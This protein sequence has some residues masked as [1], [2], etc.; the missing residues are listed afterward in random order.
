MLT[1]PFQRIFQEVQGA[2]SGVFCTEEYSKLKPLVYWVS[3]YPGAGF[4]DS[5]PCGED[6]APA[7]V[8]LMP[9]EI[10]SYTSAR[11][12]APPGTKSASLNIALPC[13]S[14]ITSVSIIADQ[15][16]YSQEDRPILEINVMETLTK[17]KM[18]LVW[19]TFD[20]PGDS[21]GTPRNTRSWIE[22]GTMVSYPL[23][24]STHGSIIFIK[25]SLPENAGPLA[26]IH[27]G[28][29]L[30]SGKPLLT[31]KSLGNFVHYPITNSPQIPDEPLASSPEKSVTDKRQALQTTPPTL[32]SL[33]KKSFVNNIYFNLF[34]LIFFYS[35]Q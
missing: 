30:I 6:S 28:K 3:E 18:S 16:G 10:V 26:R 24:E 27:M 12:M 29:I 25:V 31:G 1:N 14:L 19:D 7:E 32:F 4:I 21:C 35:T 34:F 8:L 33:P 15:Q 9:E 11:W 2:Q 23:E 5:V 22:G 17:E 20:E 13:E